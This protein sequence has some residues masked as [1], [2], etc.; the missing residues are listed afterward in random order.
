MNG[1]LLRLR[2]SHPLIESYILV[3]LAPLGATL[4]PNT[5]TQ[6]YIQ[7]VFAVKGRQ[8]LISEQTR[9]RIEKYITGLVQNKG[10]KLYAIYCM[11]DHLHLFI[12]MKPDMAIS[13]LVRVAKS[14]STKFINDNNLIAGKFSWQE[15]FGAFS[16]A[17][18]QVDTV[19]KYVLNQ[20]EHHQQSTFKEEYLLLLKRFNV[21]YDERYLFTWIE[22]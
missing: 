7:I 4:M 16:Y 6:L 14:E 5:Y 2:R 1:K 10:Q 11:P 12:S 9:E 13:D 19:V 3:N 22:D 15:G 20:P 21:E 17:Q 18:S 8:N